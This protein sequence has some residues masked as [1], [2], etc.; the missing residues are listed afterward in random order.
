MAKR[1]SAKLTISRMV[2]LEKIQQLRTSADRIDGN[3]VY[4]DLQPDV[5]EMHE[6]AQLLEMAFQKAE[7]T[8]AAALAAT[9]ALKA[10]E[11]AIDNLLAEFVLK[12]NLFSK[13]NETYIKDLNLK[14]ASD[15]RTAKP[16]PQVVNLKLQVGQEI[17]TLLA[18]WQNEKEAQMYNIQI[19]Y[20]IN[21]PETWVFFDNSSASQLLLTGLTSGELIWVRVQAIGS[22]SRKGA[23]SDPARKTVP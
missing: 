13:G 5:V 18:K 4:A 6:L 22:G 21:D 7:A 2:V 1:H 8:R 11:D 3:P 23:W 14:T 19:S 16:M 12:V 15:S 17:G 9:A 10:Q 20:D